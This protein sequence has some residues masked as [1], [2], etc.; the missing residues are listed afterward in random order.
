[1]HGLESE[2]LHLA[3]SLISITGDTERMVKT[4]EASTDP[5]IAERTRKTSIQSTKGTYLRRKAL[6]EFF[7]IGAPCLLKSERAKSCAL[8]SIDHAQTDGSFLN[9]WRSFEEGQDTAS[10]LRAAF[11]RLLEE[12]KFISYFGLLHCS[13]NNGFDHFDKS[14][15]DGGA[16]NHEKV[17]T[18]LAG[19]SQSQPLS[20]ALRKID[21]EATKYSVSR[22]KLLRK[23]TASHSGRGEAQ[24]QALNMPLENRYGLRMRKYMQDL[25][26]RKLALSSPGRGADYYRHYEPMVMGSVLI[27]EAHPLAERLLKDMPV[28]EV[29][30][31]TEGLLKDMPV[32]VHPLAEWLL[33][34]A[35]VVW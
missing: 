10:E 33:K 16:Y 8:F 28:A 17:C 21:T 32:E 15:D 34:N 22:C 19:A 4:M 13:S 12:P 1:M 25:K 29:H 26:E 2:G 30:P 31:L 6:K 11:K 20:E 35:P 14:L 3:D 27:V 7:D 5:L 24:N 18:V 23:S 9:G